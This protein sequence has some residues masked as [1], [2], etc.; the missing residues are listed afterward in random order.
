MNILV[1]ATNSLASEP[2]QILSITKVRSGLAQQGLWSS[3]RLLAPCVQ[4]SPKFV[5]RVGLAGYSASAG[6]WHLMVS[7]E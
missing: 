5:P 3:C 7:L 4:P 2:M 6:H 1:A